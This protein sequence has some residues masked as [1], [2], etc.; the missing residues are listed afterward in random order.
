MLE[1]QPANVA[2]RHA[3]RCKQVETLAVQ[4]ADPEAHRLD[5]NRQ[6]KPVDDLPE[7]S[8]E[9]LARYGG[10]RSFERAPFRLS[11]R[12]LRLHVDPGEA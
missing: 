10:D 11:I 1:R 6:G 8:G 4:F 7:R 9:I 2:E 12:C 5:R 3:H